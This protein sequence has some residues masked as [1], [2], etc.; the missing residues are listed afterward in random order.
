VGSNQVGRQSLFAI[1]DAEWT[2]GDKLK[3]FM[4]ENCELLALG[5]E[6]AF[7]P[8]SNHQNARYKISFENDEVFIFGKCCW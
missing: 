1:Q 3:P 4:A 6:F 2:L 7:F 5:Q 8:E